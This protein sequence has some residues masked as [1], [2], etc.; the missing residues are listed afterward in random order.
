MPV[1]KH[2]ESPPAALLHPV[3]RDARIHADD[4][5]A[6]RIRAFVALDHNPVQAAGLPS[7]QVAFEA[8]H[9]RFGKRFELRE[10]AV[11]EFLFFLPAEVR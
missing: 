5:R 1:S 4:G 7:Y 11:H 10:D 8:E 9:Q 2:A 3:L 6:L